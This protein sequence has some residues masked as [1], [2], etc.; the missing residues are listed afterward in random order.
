VQAAW[1]RGADGAGHTVIDL[2]QGWFLGHEDLPRGI[3]LLAGL[4]R[5]ESHFHGCA[6]LGELVAIDDT[7]GVAGI[8]PGATARLVSY[9]DP[10]ITTIPANNARIASRVALA[11]RALRRGDVL[12]MEVQVHGEV[13]GVDHLVPAETDRAVSDAV[14]LAT[15]AG[16]VVVAAAGNG[17]LDLD[18]WVDPVT[19]A[20]TLN[21]NFGLEF[22]ESRAILVGSC[23]TDIPP[24]G[25]M[26]AK[27]PASNFGSRVDC[28]A[29][30]DN[31]LTTGNPDAP[32]QVDGYM[33]FFG[34][35]S[36]AS[37]IIAGVCLLVQH[38]QS[39]LPVRP[40]QAQGTLER[41]M[42]SLLNDPAVGHPVAGSAHPMPDFERL[43]PRQY[44][45]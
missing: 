27:M 15:A 7:R 28:W 5:L 40:G 37:A 6:V 30:G 45:V 39:L 34:G 41:S 1:A 2:E 35:T 8:A 26:R 3:P 32:D 25:L 16:V 22:R 23:T 18:S 9:F 11:A 19:G 21:R 13:G 43:I 33:T 12:L 14:R 42:R 24:P 4:N 38:L 31:I 29:W 36:G 17:N 44:A 20:H 10:A